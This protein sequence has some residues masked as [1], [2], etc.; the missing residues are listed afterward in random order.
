M[1]RRRKD[2]GA[3]AESLLTAGKK[4]VAAPI[5]AGTPTGRRDAGSGGRAVEG[6]TTLAATIPHHLREVQALLPATAKERFICRV[7]GGGM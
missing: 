3:G 1:M 5:S 2:E 7:P 6:A 4:G